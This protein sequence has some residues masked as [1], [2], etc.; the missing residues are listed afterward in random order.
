MDGKEHD[1]Y[2]YVRWEVARKALGVRA[3]AAASSNKL[4][5]ARVAGSADVVVDCQ[6]TTDVWKKCV[7]QSPGDGI[8]VVCDSVENQMVCGR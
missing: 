5:V 6:Y 4:E 7:M 1:R 8:D 2:Q 3:I